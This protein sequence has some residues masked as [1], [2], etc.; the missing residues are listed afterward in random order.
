MNNSML[1]HDILPKLI[2]LILVNRKIYNSYFVFLVKF[3]ARRYFK[4][5]VK[6]AIEE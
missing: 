2:L 3:T 4:K 1:L 6:L 5:K